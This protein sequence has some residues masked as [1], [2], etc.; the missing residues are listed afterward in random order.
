[1][2]TRSRVLTGNLTAAQV[3]NKFLDVDW[4]VVK[5]R[6]NMNQTLGSILAQSTQ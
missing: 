5:C 1:M 3:V 6:S 2:T 4:T